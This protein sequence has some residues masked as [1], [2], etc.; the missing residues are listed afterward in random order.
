MGPKT[1][2]KWGILKY[3]SAEFFSEK[4]DNIPNQRVY[5]YRVLG[6]KLGYDTNVQPST[7][8]FFDQFLLKNKNRGNT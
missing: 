6:Q 5:E 7:Q 4:S 2:K 8:I 1:N 3:L